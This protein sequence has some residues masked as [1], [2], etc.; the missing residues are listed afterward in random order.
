MKTVSFIT[1]HVGFNFGSVLQSI[2]T[3]EVIK[4]VGG[5]PLLII[6]YLLVLLIEDILKTSNP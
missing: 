5:S 3:A 1:I 6:M 2:A 4:K